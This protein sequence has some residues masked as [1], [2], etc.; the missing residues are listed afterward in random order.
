MDFSS[1][2]SAVVPSAY[3]PVLVALAGAGR[4]LSGRQIA[5]LV[6][7]RVGR[8]RVNAILG[9]LTASGVVRCSSHPPALVYELNGEHVAAPLIIGLAGLRSALFDRMRACASGWTV[10]ADAVWL[11]GSAARGEGAVDSD[12]DVLVVRP[13]H[14]ATDDAGWS[15]QL[16]D[17]S[18]KVGRWSGNSCS[19]LEMGRAELNAAVERRD[20]L[21]D[22]LRR[23][24]VHITGAMPLDLLRQS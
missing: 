6:G 9:E 8:S 11:F 13:E 1:P 18:S 20:R 7:G 19:I 23:D 4:P 24:A 15:S 21:V 10:P 22:E 12:I 14:V 5:G 17:L 2:I 16:D 3:G